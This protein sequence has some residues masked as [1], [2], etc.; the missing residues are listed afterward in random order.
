MVVREESEVD[1]D[2]LWKSEEYER[3]ERTIFVTLQKGFSFLMF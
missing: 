2:A 3:E 1:S